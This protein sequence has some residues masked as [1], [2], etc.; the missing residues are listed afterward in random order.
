MRETGLEAL[1][2]GLARDLAYLNYPPENW[3]RP[4]Q[5]TDGRHVY[6]VVIVGAGMC[7][8]TAAFALL[9][10]GIAN[11]RIVDNS[12][13]GFEGPWVTYARMNTLRSPKH[14]T[15]PAMGL[16]ALTCRAWF[17]ARF[18]AAAWEALDKIPR[19][20]WMDYLRWYRR[21][22]N[23]PVENDVT[24]QTIEPYGDLLGLEIDGASEPCLTGKIVLAN[25]RDGVGGLRIPAFANNLPRACWNH[26]KDD[27][28]FDALV[29]KRVAVLGASASA[30]DNAAVA[31]ETGAGAVH[32]F[33][34][35]ADLPRINKFKGVIYPGFT[36]GFPTLNDEWRWRLLHYA[37]DQGVA[38]PQDSMLRLKC[39]PNFALH[40]GSPW[41]RV[42][43]VG[44]EIEIET[45]KGIHRF[46]H[47]ILATGFTVDADKRAEL[48]GLTDKI[49]LWG[50][51]IDAPSDRTSQDLARFPYLGPAFEFM[52]TEP[53]A[54]PHLRHI[55]CFNYA[56]TLSHG[57][58]SGDIPNVSEGAQ[59]LV[60]GIARDFFA[61]DRAYHFQQLQ[62][63]DELELLGDEW[64]DADAVLE[65]T[66]SG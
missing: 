1:E 39:H 49:L 37:L 8:L 57:V 22:L 5:S 20:M 59:R 45:P 66:P 31:L 4:Q 16:P 51:R 21:V 10:A 23:L 36:H 17:E 54:A 56:A 3:V 38:P 60:E 55:H 40:L 12:E 24:V 42:E 43:T 47:L 53:G 33:V 34:R 11:I 64:I 26:S 50:D 35:R 44:D 15:G 30:C 46:D 7:G 9:R 48:A 61:A 14:L 13:P 62:D 52:E 2:A 65:K 27:I 6:D 32:M 19:T 63:Y 58:V 41:H 28:D 29:G 18:G 25:G